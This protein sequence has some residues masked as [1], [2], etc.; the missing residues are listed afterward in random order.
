MCQYA[1]SAL[2][3]RISSFRYLMPG[4]C[5]KTQPNVVATFTSLS[6]PAVWPA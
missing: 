1:R 5:L 6:T 2:A 4:S 3:I